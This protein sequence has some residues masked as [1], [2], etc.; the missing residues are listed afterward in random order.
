M[1]TVLTCPECDASLKLKAPP[2]PGKKIRC[3]KCEAIF[4]PPDDGDDRVSAE[5]PAAKSRPRPVPE[6]EDDTREARRPRRPAPKQKGGKGLLIGLLVGGGVLVLM[7]LGCVGVGGYLLYHGATQVGRDGKVPP[8]GAQAKAGGQAQPFPGPA[9]PPPAGGGAPNAGG[10]PKG[11]GNPLPVQEAPAGLYGDQGGEEVAPADPSLPD[12]LLRARAG[13][14]FYKISNARI[15]TGRFPG[16]VLFVDYEIVKQGQYNGASLVIHGDDG[17]HQQVLLFGGLRT[18]G[19]LEIESRGFGFPG[20]AAF[21]QTCELYMTRGDPRYG[22]NA[23]TFKVSNSTTIGMMNRQ[24]RARNWT[25]EEIDRLSKPPPNYSS[26]NAHPDVGQDTPFAGDST[27]GGSFRYVEPNG[28]LLGL[29]YRVAEWEGEKAL[30]GV[31]PVFTRDQPVSPACLRVLA[32]EGYAVG[33]AKVRSKR[34]VDAVQLVFMRVKP[35]GRLDPADS[36]TS[37]WFG[38]AGDQP[39][40]TLAGDGTRV[41]GIHCRQGAIL[42]GLALVV[43]KNGPAKP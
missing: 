21:P 18:H 9:N 41:N 24:T 39:L 26:P 20:R 2:A 5:R 8:P 42:N 11:G 32:K 6:D 13:D 30:G 19:T 4:A 23:P 37:E 43:D 33:G 28:L 25:K 36:Y 10:A 29:D 27:G 40:K 35:D 34:F 15:G 3:P 16:P 31:V 7:V 38:D 14:T 17:R 12:T 22:P 1:A